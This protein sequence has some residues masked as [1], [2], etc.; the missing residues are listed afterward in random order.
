CSRTSLSAIGTLSLHDALPILGERYQIS[1]ERQDEFAYK[2]HHQAAAAWDGGKY[3]SWTLPVAGA[4]LDR[5]E[6]VRPDTSMEKLAKL[7]RSEEHTSELQSRFEL[8]CRL[9]L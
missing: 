3:D 2:S 6:G 5:D 9:L 8:V 1:R 7:R 4:D